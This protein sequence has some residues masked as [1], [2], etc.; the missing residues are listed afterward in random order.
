MGHDI[1]LILG[2]KRRP[3]TETAALLAHQAHAGQVR[4]DDGS[5]YF[6]HPCMVAFK[7]AHNGFD[8]TV[9]AAGFVH[10]V[11]EDTEVTKDELERSLG[12]AVVGL[13]LPLS[14]D[15]SLPWEERKRRYI[16]AMRSAP[17]GTKAVS[18][19]DKI[20]NAESLLAA[21]ESQGPRVWDAFSRGKKQ[22]LWFE[23]SVLDALKEGWSHPL[24]E[25]YA[26]LVARLESRA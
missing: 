7:L 10:D 24:I 2:A 13:I 22:K 17:E 25:E 21:L 19:A 5:P 26:Q 12:P 11:L 14:E 18:V 1:G 3:L 20:H 6:I 9:V 16:D 4:K 23:R 15:K 8:E